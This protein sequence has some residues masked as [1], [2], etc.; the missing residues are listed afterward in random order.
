MCP[1][2]LTS[3]LLGRR[4]APLRGKGLITALVLHRRELDPL[5]LRLTR[6]FDASASFRCNMLNHAGCLILNCL[7][8]PLWGALHHGR[9]ERLGGI[10]PPTVSLATKHSTSE[11]QPHYSV[12]CLLPGLVSRVKR[13]IGTGARAN[14]TPCSMV[15]PGLT[16][17]LRCRFTPLHR[18]S[19]TASWRTT[20]RSIRRPSPLG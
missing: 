13:N 20:R 11:L 12:S 10:E 18:A 5:T 8:F 16:V 6:R 4:P 19:A 9:L 17:S 15:D 3:S 14:K 1:R 2:N 7:R